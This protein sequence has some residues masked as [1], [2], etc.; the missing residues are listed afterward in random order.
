MNGR[1]TTNINKTLKKY[2]QIRPA[3]GL[4]V[5]RVSSVRALK[6]TRCRTQREKGTLARQIMK[7]ETCIGNGTA[8]SVVL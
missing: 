4:C 6:V 8:L 1:S 3:G 5:Q 2:V 7:T